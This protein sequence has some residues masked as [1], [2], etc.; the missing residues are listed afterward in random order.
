MAS[1][2]YSQPEEGRIWFPI[3]PL[4][5]I[6]RLHA[7]GNLPT[8][9]VAE[10]T[11]VP[12]TAGP[13]T[14]WS[15]ANFS[16]LA[17]GARGIVGETVCNIIRCRTRNVGLIVGNPDARQNFCNE[18][19]SNVRDG[20]DRY[21]LE[22]RSVHVHEPETDIV[23]TK[24]EAVEIN[25]DAIE[26]RTDAVEVNPD[27]VEVRTDAVEVNPDAVEVNP[28]AVETKAGAVK[29]EPKTDSDLI[30]VFP[31]RSTIEVKNFGQ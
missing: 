13:D 28:D 19:F 7:K 12:F 5:Y 6:L 24:T 30:L 4:K 10:F 26:V 8:T 11:I 20:L 27:A 2:S 22:L 1:S 29:T 14:L 25:P 18:V 16:A 31:D 17:T 3:T 9:L 23:E 21:G 15:L